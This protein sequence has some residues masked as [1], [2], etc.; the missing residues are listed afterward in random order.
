MAK[1]L[2]EKF[3]MRQNWR[4]TLAGG[5]SAKC[6]K[7]CAVFCLLSLIN[8]S[9]IW[10]WETFCCGRWRRPHYGCEVRAPMDQIYSYTPFLLWTFSHSHEL[11]NFPRSAAVYDATAALQRVPAFLRPKLLNFAPVKQKWLTVRNWYFRPCWLLFL[12]YPSTMR[13]A[14]HSVDQTTNFPKMNSA[15]SRTKFF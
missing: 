7:R 2:K 4:V 15:Y 6:C 14:E 12:P 10:A 3:H 8:L 9:R 1:Y 5:C 11:I 13:C